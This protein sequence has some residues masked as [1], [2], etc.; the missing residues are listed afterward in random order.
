MNMTNKQ[1]LFC[2]SLLSFTAQAQQQDTLKGKDIEEVVVTATRSE[3]MLSTVPMPV[4][5][6]TKSQIQQM[7]SVRLQE[8]LQEQTGLTLTSSHGQGVQLQG[9]N[10]DYTLI[11]ID[12]EPLIGRTAGTLELSRI[13]V[14]NIK[15]IEIVKGATSSL[16]GSEA[17]AG[18]INIITENPRNQQLS[19]SGRYGT[20]QMAD[21]SMQAA[22]SKEKWKGNIFLNR[23][24]SAGYD[25]NPETQGKTVE[26]FHAYTAQSKWTYEINKHLQASFSGRYFNEYQHSGF[27][28]GSPSQWISGGGRVQDWNILPAFTYRPS[29]RWKLQQ[30]LYYSS[31]QAQSELYTPD[32]QLFEATNF[33]QTFFRPELQSNYILSEKHIFTLGIGNA[34][35]SVTATR[36]EGTKYFQNLYAYAQHEWLPTQRWN[37]VAGVRA[38]V[39]TVY[40]SQLSPKLAVQYE[41]N[42]WLKV[43]GSW[44]RGFKAPDFRQLYLNFTNTVAGYSVFGTEEITNILLQLQQQNQL[45][46]I[47]ISTEALTQLKAESSFAYNIGVKLQPLKK[48]QAN[49]NFFRNDVENL[50]ESQAVARRT[51]GQNI[52]SYRNLQSIYTQGVEIDANYQIH[53]TVSLSVG[54]QY[55]DAKDKNVIRQIEEGEIFRRDPQT[56]VTSRVTSA[57]YGG[58]MGRSRHTFN[59]KI[60]YQ[61]AK[62]WEA[63]FRAIYR[64]RQGWADRNGNL[65]LDEDNE[66]MPDF[67]TFN[68]S[69]SKYFWNKK[70][71]WQIGVDNLGDFTQAT[72]LPNVAGRLWWTSLQLQLFKKE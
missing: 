54:Y 31:Y 17:L 43:R 11:L 59:T 37:V 51:N 71:R 13:A 48:L 63:T 62:G 2:L 30:R 8:V 19:L 61:N 41:V 32:N 65:I 21:L 42:E 67:W 6:I 18:V 52:F 40:G 16:Y 60:F 57:D 34:W 1:L 53:S 10:P 56:L 44:G 69:M 70:V 26:P 64:G 36:Y 35:E 24:S 28:I 27:E 38:D 72:Y 4:T 58:L 20:N 33:Y 47:L 9:F 66:Y 22:L 7:G 3:K 45:A 55:L 46:D 39:H 12:G 14:G 15:Q 49:I 25:L 68:A 29:T 5:I 50:I 23:Y